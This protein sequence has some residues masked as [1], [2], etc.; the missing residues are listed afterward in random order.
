MANT[1]KN[2][3]LAALTKGLTP[4]QVE[5]LQKA[6]VAIVGC[7]GLGS[8][9]AMELTRT[10]IGTLHLIDFDK[11]DLSNLNRQAYFLEDVGSYK[12]D[13]LAKYL[14]R[15]NPYL[16]LQLTYEPITEY[17]YQKLLQ[18]ADFIC[19]ALDKPET[20]AMLVSNILVDFPNKPLVSASGIAGL[21]K[22]EEITTK[23]LRNNF[24]LSG[25]GCSDFKNNPLCSARVILCA[26]HQA[27]TLIRLILGLE[28]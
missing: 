10:G 17:N 25:D 26:S 28:N 7:G 11:V 22:P 3:L 24:Y 18:K 2:T 4:Q 14:K 19:E 6:H 8:N 16:Q 5:Q 13:A 9:I 20:K 12:I 23:Q 21:G 15:I 27:L 1:D